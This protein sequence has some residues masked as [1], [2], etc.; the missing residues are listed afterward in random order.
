MEDK[1]I[2]CL[3]VNGGV[4]AIGRATSSASTTSPKPTERSPLSPP[5]RTAPLAARAHPAGSSSSKPSPSIASAAS[6]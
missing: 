3:R 2:G 4:I 6:R 1:L 5:E